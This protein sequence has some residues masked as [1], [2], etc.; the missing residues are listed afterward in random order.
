MKSKKPIIG[1]LKRTSENIIII[2][3]EVLEGCDI[4]TFC[5]S[6]HK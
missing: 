4:R 2:H 5:H 3:F 6:H 1:S